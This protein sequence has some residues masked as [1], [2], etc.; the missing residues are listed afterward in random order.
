MRKLLSLLLCCAALG[1]L[2][3]SPAA[4]AD[5]APAE[6]AAVGFWA[7]E[8]YLVDGRSKSGYPAGPGEYRAERDLSSWT[9]ELWE[10]LRRH[11]T[12]VY[13]H[14]RYGQD[15]GA[16][17]SDTGA[18]SI[19]HRANS[20]GVP[21]FAWVA[22]P[23][24]DGYWATQSNAEVQMAATVALDGWA[25][26]NRLELAG[27][28]YDQEPPLETVNALA[29]GRFD[30]SRPVRSLDPA[31][32]HHAIRQYEAVYDYA[33]E[34]FAQAIGAPVPF[35]L[36]DLANDDLALQ[37]SLD[38]WGLP[39]GAQSLFFQAYRSTIA[40]VMGADPGSA[41]IAH[42]LRLAQRTL[43]SERG[44]VTLGVAGDGVYG[45]LDTLVDDVRL[46]RALGATSI[47]VYALENAAAA[48]G[49][50]GVERLIRAGTAPL[51]QDRVRAAERP[52]P[53][54]ASYLSVMTALDTAATAGT[55]PATAAT[56]N[57]QQPNRF[58]RK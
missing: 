50:D 27:I 25:R 7:G 52:T 26:D 13:F 36:D 51:D 42:Y 46:A 3:G 39:D 5:T 54:L 17:A 12:P 15:F 30:P 49:V 43:G 1:L 18:L 24:E 16:G 28:A 4:A 2:P 38:L 48:Y 44:L 21:V 8:Q 41:L 34:H 10:V 37:N 19:I 9:P 6:P 22:V 56:G 47:P 40:E 58:P 45:D 55:L 31:A 32:Q 35:A 33:R 14:L 53:G 11:R 23:Y 29:A 20:L 57:P